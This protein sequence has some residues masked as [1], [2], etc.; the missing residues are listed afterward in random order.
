MGKLMTSP[1]AWRFSKL[2]PKN[3]KLYSL[4]PKL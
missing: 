4:T 3:S 2:Y 1:R